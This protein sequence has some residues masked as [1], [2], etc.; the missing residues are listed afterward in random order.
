MQFYLKRHNSNMRAFTIIPAVLT[1]IQIIRARSVPGTE[2]NNLDPFMCT[3]FGKGCYLH[4]DVVT[5]VFTCTCSTN[6]KNLP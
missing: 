5:G 3:S 2:I 6:P 4:L 1:M